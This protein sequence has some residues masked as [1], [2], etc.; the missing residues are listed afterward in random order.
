MSKAPTAP[1]EYCAQPFVDSLIPPNIRPLIRLSHGNTR[2][3]AGVPPAEPPT[4][5]AVATLVNTLCRT[6]RWSCHGGRSWRRLSVRRVV[7]DIV[8]SEFTGFFRQSR[9]RCRAHGILGHEP[10]HVMFLLWP[11]QIQRPDRLAKRGSQDRQ[12]H[13]RTWR[14]DS[15]TGAET[16]P[17]RRHGQR[18]DKA[19][20]TAAGSPLARRARLPACGASRAASFNW[21]ASD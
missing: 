18:R 19:L 1:S 7:S 9:H 20:S 16:L 8:D 3:S 15:A 13:G 4:A 12:A 5:F 10:G 11:E 21:A 2:R 17:A 6:S 14:S